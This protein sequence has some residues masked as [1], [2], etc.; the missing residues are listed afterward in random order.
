MKVH[1]CEICECPIKPPINYLFIY[2]EEELNKEAYVLNKNKTVPELCKECRAI[3]EKIL[4]VRKQGVKKLTEQLE[5]D[6]KLTHKR[7]KKK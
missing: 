3:V 2:T 1:F 6:F 4:K 5:Q 7:R